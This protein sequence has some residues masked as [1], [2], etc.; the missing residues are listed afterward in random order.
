MA[1]IINLRS[2]YSKEFVFHGTKIPL[3]IKALN[4]HEAT[5]F[6]KLMYRAAKDWQSA[7][8]SETSTTENIEALSVLDQPEVR[9]AFERFVRVPAGVN[10]DDEPATAGKLFDEGSPM[11]IMTVL[12]AIQSM[13]VLTDVE[14]FTSGSLST[15][16]VVAG[17]P[18]T[19]SPASTTAATVS[20]TSSTV[21][22]LSVETPSLSVA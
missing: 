11:F 16:G 1:D 15:S 12:T 3:E 14:S 10:F 22:G 17:P 5:P 20:P 2:W 13:A 18:T 8:G 6:V 4:K 7:G 21:T 19:A 9:A